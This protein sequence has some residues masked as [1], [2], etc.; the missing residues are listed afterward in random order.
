[1]SSFTPLI[2]NVT[3]FIALSYATLAPELFLP[4][5]VVGDAVDV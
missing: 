3:Y 1:M 5:T 2:A 4:F